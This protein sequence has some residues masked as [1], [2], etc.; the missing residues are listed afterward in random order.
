M[1]LFPI[2]RTCR[3]HGVRLLIA[4]VLFGATPALARAQL[5]KQTM[6]FGGATRTWYVH[7]PASYDGSKAVPL[8]LALHGVFNTGD[9]FAPQSEWTPVSDQQGFIVVYPNGG[10]VYNPTSLGW[11]SY[12]YDGSAPDDTG[13]LV[14]LIST[15][16]SEYKIDPDRIYMAGFSNGGGMANT[17]CVNGHAGLLAAINCSSASWLTTFGTSE[18]S[19]KPGGTVSTWISRGSLE[20]DAEG[21]ETLAVQDANETAYFAGLDGCN[22]TPQTLT[23]GRYVTSIYTG[24]KGEVRFTMVTGYAHQYGPGFAQKI[25][26]DFFSRIVRNVPPTYPPTAAPAV[27]GGLSAVGAVGTPFSFPITTSNAPTGFAGASLPDGLSVDPIY[28]LLN[29][30]P[31]TAGT[32]AVTLQATNGVGTGSGTLMLAI[33]P[34]YVQPAFFDGQNS[35]GEG[36]YYLQF[37][38][39]NF[40]GYYSYLGDPDY[41]YHFDLG[42]EYVYDAADG[43]SGV[44][45]YD[46][47]SG[48]FFYS[49]PG[50]PF[51]YL[52]D[53]ALNSVVYYYPDPSNPGHY[54]TNGLRYFYVFNSGEVV[55][56]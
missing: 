20:T 16:E 7:L 37:P 49:S 10:L 46:F 41:L 2:F 29:G 18:T 34:A 44:Y 12:V 56:L 51:P 48:G 19:L 17:F 54:N 24:G 35:L 42:Y 33:A 25:W 26:N 11:N 50:F 14:Q 5:V 38:S 40:F 15:L 28:G 9:Q 8:V 23:Q 21:S 39:G 43:N 1:A 4:G 13:F 30:T 22:A 55:T 53:F 6:S 45:F 32:S 47:A 36:V 3:R 27:P 52:Y 31:A